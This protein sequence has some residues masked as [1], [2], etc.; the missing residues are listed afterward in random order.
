[1]L[2][3]VKPKRAADDAHA[4]TT[5]TAVHARA[6]N[7]RSHPHRVK[8][9][10]QRE[11][12]I[13]RGW[14]LAY[15]TLQHVL[16]KTGRNWANNFTDM[17]KGNTRSIRK[18]TNYY[19]LSFDECVRAESL[20][21]K[22]TEWK[23]RVIGFMVI[24]SKRSPSACLASCPLWEQ[25]PPQHSSNISQHTHTHTHTCR[26]TIACLSPH[27]SGFLQTHAPAGEARSPEDV[28]G[29]QAARHRSC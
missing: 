18:L 8:C 20:G 17:C 21:S 23:E 4:V 16:Y 14:E 11:G 6:R 28:N 3:D 15:F 2:L 7:S 12:E 1:M 29:V 19:N 26:C 10:W 25:N 24:Y 22:E 27:Y 5:T 9:V 13:A